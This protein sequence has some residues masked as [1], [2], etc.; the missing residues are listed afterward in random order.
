MGE[1]IGVGG[2]TE[3]ISATQSASDV[4]ATLYLLS[5]SQLALTDPYAWLAN[6]TILLGSSVAIQPNT[7]NTPES[8]HL[9]TLQNSWTG[10]LWVRRQ[11]EAGVAALLT[12]GTLVPGTKTDGTLVATLSGVYT[13]NS[14]QY[15]PIAVDVTAAAGSQS[16][17]W[18]IDNAG[19]IKCYGCGSAGN[20]GHGILPYW[21]D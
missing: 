7:S 18:G 12:T 16:P 10:S 6:S 5:K 15:P 3:I 8:W 11:T 20:V 17:H 1:I 14:D 9:L 2:V 19:N 13:P 4:A 21:L